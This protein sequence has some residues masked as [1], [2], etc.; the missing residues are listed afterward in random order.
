MNISRVEQRVLHV[1]ARGGLILHEREGR[2]IVAVACVDRDGAIL[3][4]CTLAVFDR[5][6]R[7]RLIESHGSRPYRI[8]LAGRQAVRSQPDNRQ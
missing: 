6:R 7:R 1:L 4:D 8:A 5:L 3:S 2:R